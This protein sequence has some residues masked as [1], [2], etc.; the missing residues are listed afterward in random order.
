[1]TKQNKEDKLLVLEVETKGNK[2][3]LK[4][5]IDREQAMGLYL[6]LKDILLY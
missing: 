5:E 4:V 2:K 6:E 3:S 1:M